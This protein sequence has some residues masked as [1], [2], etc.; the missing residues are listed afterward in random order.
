MSSANFQTDNAAWSGPRK[1]LKVTE[2]SCAAA[3]HSFYLMSSL[4]VALMP[5]TAVSAQTIEPDLDETQLPTQSSTSAADLRITPRWTINYNSANGGFDRGLTGF[6]G[7]IPVIQTPGDSLVYLVPR[8]SLDNSANLGGSLLAGY[9][10]LSG[11]T[12]F[13]GYTGVDFRNTGRSDFTQLSAGLEAFGETW[14][15]HFNAYLP[16]G[17]TRNQVTSGGSVG[18]NPRFRENQLV[19]DVG[20]FNQVEAA[21]NG[22]DL[23]GGFRLAEFSN[24][25]G[26]LW[27]YP[28]L[29]YYGGNESEDSLGVRM[30]LDYRLQ[31][32][33]RFGLGIQHD[34]LFGTN[35][36]FS[37][38]AI[39]GGPVQPPDGAE[40]E[41]EALLWARAAEPVTRNPVVIVDNQ[42]VIETQASN[43]VAVNPATGQAYN[44]IHV[45]PDNA[46]ADQGAGTVA[47]PFTTLG[48]SGGA[49]TTALG[50]ANPNDIV[51]VRPGN[52]AANAIPGFTIPAGVQVRS[53]GV[54][55]TLAIA[56]TLGTTSVNLPNF[57]DL[58]TL[59]RVTGGGNNG[60]TLVGGNNLLSGFDI[61]N[62]DNGIV[63]NNAA[64]VVVRDNVIVQPRFDAIRVLDSPNAQILSNQIIQPEDEGL[65][66]ANS[67]NSVVSNN[68][69]TQIGERGLLI[70][71]SSG[72]TVSNNTI[73]QSGEEGIEIDGS[74]N[75]VVVGNTVIAARR[76]GIY[77]E[78]LNGIE[79]RDNTVQQTTTAGLGRP[80]GIYLED[81]TG[82]ITLSGNSV[83]GTVAGGGNLRVEGQGIA[84]RNNTGDFNLTLSG[85]TVGGANAGSG[86]AGDGIVVSL[87]GNATGTVSILNNRIEGNGTV[88]PLAGDGIQVTVEN[89]ANLSNLTISN[90][91]ILNNF[92]DGIDLRVGSVAA[93]GA[94]LRAL[95]SGNTI[96]GHTNGQGI[97]VVTQ[98]SAI[99]PGTAINGSSQTDI[100]IQQNTLNNNATDIRAIAGGAAPGSTLCLRIQNNTNQDVINLSTA[101]T[102][103]LQLEP[104]T[105]NANNLA[106]IAANAAANTCNTP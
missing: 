40:V 11:N 19:F 14:D 9:R 16:I 8:V 95:L 67:P 31:D 103:T 1:R 46:N 6:E 21:L 69:F 43:I 66:L 101:N 32:N 28:G 68:Q 30:R 94:Q 55:Q 100:A 41:P 53:S 64:N 76:A 77:V 75:S 23:E 3:R 58:G 96:T 85:N 90:N 84:L 80:A 45:S 106:T 39:V 12:L 5:M 51:Y 83:T 98:D 29:Y 27:A 26:N 62:A 70:F 79:V 82:T 56:P 71:N 44:F 93:T 72:T 105:G 59:P 73:N 24:D 57:G 2:I 22:V 91:Q 4:L 42:T 78:Q 88:A 17:D 52:T 61:R 99:T 54:V 25:W 37:V 10:F 60:V 38:N 65:E 92:D 33:L 13:G 49:A 36:F 81:V 97:N 47:N 34:G 48:N 74:A 35:V 102:G 63:A 89:G 15:V 18:L 7:F 50:N 104:L 86:N 20:Q 87:G